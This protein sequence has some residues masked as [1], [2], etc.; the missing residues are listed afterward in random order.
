[1][2]P[3]TTFSVDPEILLDTY[4]RIRA[5]T[6]TLCAPLSIEDYGIQSMPDASPPKWH[7][8]HTNWFFETFVLIPHLPSYQQAHPAYSYLF[9]SYYEGAGPQFP[10]PK[11][12]TLSR[13]TVQE[14]LAWRHTVDDAMM[15]ALTS[16]RFDEH[17]L[18]LIELGLHHEEQHQELLIVDL[19]HGL[20]QNPIEVPIAPMPRAPED[21]PD[22]GWVN[23]N[24]GLVEIGH[25]GEGFAFDNELPRHRTF[26]EDFRLAKSLIT[27]GEYLK[28]IMDG[29]YQRPEL[30]LSDAWHLLQKEQWYAPLYWNPLTD[31]LPLAGSIPPRISPTSSS[32]TAHHNFCERTLGGSRPLAPHAPVTH[33]SFYEADAYARWRGLRLPTEAEWEHAA[34]TTPNLTTGTVLEDGVFHPEGRKT[35]G[36]NNELSHLLG[37]VWEHTAS[38][39]RPYP[40]FAP[41]P[42]VVGEY[43]GKFMNGQ[44]VL[45]GG[46]AA[47]PRDHIRVSYRNFF[48]ADKR[49]I[50]T[51]I[52]LADGQQS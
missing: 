43:N 23:I 31:A 5:R 9:N 22:P 29:G 48:A 37:E 2:R 3:T 19:K 14:V 36:E 52:R 34:S 15:G 49:W 38:P 20:L 10:R 21:A 6:E 24:G 17:I 4:R 7:L 13:P 28:F 18:A 42:G 46:S 30:W 51:G 44:Y 1:M 11:R 41:H 27:N 33:V 32:D 47:T 50:F 12:G 25:S 39:Y 26:L 45:K 16:H 35:T 40:G 8:A